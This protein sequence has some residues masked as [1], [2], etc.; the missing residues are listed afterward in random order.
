M[1][2]THVKTL[3]AP[4]DR[5]IEHEAN[6]EQHLPWIHT[7]RWARYQD[8]VPH[9][10]FHI[11]SHQDGPIT[12]P[13]GNVWKSTGSLRPTWLGAFEILAKGHL[14]GLVLG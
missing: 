12:Y 14:T 13:F 10:G 3:N 7:L 1:P 9:P 8:L 5:R 4:T 2:C 11:R 6:E